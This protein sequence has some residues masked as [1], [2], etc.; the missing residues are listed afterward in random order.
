MEQKPK[1]EAGALGLAESITMGVAGTAPAYSIEITTS[2]IIATTGILSPANILVCGLIM[3]GIA[4]AFI[5]LNKVNSNA[6]TS[7]AWVSQIFGRTPGFLA[8][9]AL[10]VLC[11]V[12]MVS[13]MVPAANATLLIVKPELMNDV[14]WVTGIAALWLTFIS[15]VLVKGIKITSYVQI[16]M[17][18]IEAAILLTIIVMAFIVFP[19]A[20]VRPFS[21]GWFSPFSFT[22]ELFATGT[23]T[24]IFFYYGWDVTM[25]LSEETRDP[26][27][28]PGRA[29][30]W[31]M[32]LLMLFF[33]VFI[34]IVLLG[35][36]DEEIQHFN[37]NIIFAI[38]EKLLGKTWG[39][40][41]II[42]VLLSTVGTVETQMLQFTRTMFAKGRDGALN[43]RY[44]RLH[45]RW[46]T[47]HVAIFFIWAAGL[48]LLFL[49]SYLSSINQ[50]LK[51]SITALGFQISFYLGLTG[52]A[53]AWYFRRTLWQA[54][55]QSFTRVVWPFASACFL[56]FIAGYSVPTFDPLTTAIGLG[57]IAIGVVPLVLN[58]R[59]MRRAAA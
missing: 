2:T 38:A 1:L 37:T 58:R 57:G 27:Q 8:G 50:I 42:A 16:A 32:I 43:P 19:A 20:P 45:P 7:Y 14:N 46:Q 26:N 39:Y 15:A 48:V 59:K 12:F 52:F 23:L 5:H 33:L 51:D 9:W 56:F 40:I 18:V 3:F 31:S 21:W 25:N 10:L 36:T 17:T 54:P 55:L 28:T 13:A 11:C 44:S 30:F 53:C 29:A 41:A 34:T 22:P 6:G 47:P 35:L 49:S 24:A 4:F